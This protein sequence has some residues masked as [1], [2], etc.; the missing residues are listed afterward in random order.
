MGESFWWHVLFSLC[1]GIVQEEPTDSPVCWFV[2]DS[3]E[4]VRENATTDAS[5]GFV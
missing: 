4:L 3:L 1:A 5:M 2:V